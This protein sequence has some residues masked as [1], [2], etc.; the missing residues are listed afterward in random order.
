VPGPIL[1]F[2]MPISESSFAAM[3]GS[4]RRSILGVVW[5][6]QLFRRFANLRRSGKSSTMTRPRGYSGDVPIRTN[7]RLAVWGSGGDRGRRPPKL[8]P[9]WGYLAKSPPTTNNWP[10]R[11]GRGLES[12]SVVG[13]TAGLESRVLQFTDRQTRDG[14]ATRNQTAIGPLRTRRSPLLGREHRRWL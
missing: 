12:P 3:T 8:W 10:K 1:N 14:R 2:F 7:A 9:F 5:R 11:G 4:E 13:P 6:T